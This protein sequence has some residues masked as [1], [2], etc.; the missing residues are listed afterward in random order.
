MIKDSTGQHG[1]KKRSAADNVDRTRISDDW[2]PPETRTAPV[3][4][5][6]ALSLTYRRSAAEMDKLRQHG[7]W[8]SSAAQSAGRKEST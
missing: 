5:L 3:A 7:A 2:R 8:V 4:R 1:T 6:R